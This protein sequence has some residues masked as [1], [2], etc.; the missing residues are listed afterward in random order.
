MGGAVKN[1]LKKAV[2]KGTLVQT[3][4]SFRVAGDPVV[5]APAEPTVQV[6]D[7]KVGTGAHA[8]PGDT[9][10]VK[11]EGKLEDGTVFDTA[12]AFEFTLGAG[13]VIKGWEYIASMQVGGQR[14]LVV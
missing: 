5:A 3:G 12:A 13:E 14:K 10:V 7:L 6:D 8:E 2:D 9:V 11:Y 1:S 4:Q